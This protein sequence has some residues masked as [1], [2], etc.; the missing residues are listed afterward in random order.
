MRDFKVGDVLVH[1]LTSKVCIVTNLLENG[2]HRL[3]AFDK[4]HPFRLA[5]T[6]LP[7][8]DWKNLGWLLIEE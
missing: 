2:E 7:L 6:S 1:Q 8:S 5:V 3:L 4:G